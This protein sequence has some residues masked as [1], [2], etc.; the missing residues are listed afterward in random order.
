MS[1]RV[2]ICS[3]NQGCLLGGQVRVGRP[4]ARVCRRKLRSHLVAACRD[5]G[6]AFV[7]GDVSKV[8]AQAAGAAASLTC[9]GGAAIQARVVIMAAGAAAGKFLQY[10]TDAPTMAAQTAYGIQVPL[11]HPAPMHP[12]GVF[13]PIDP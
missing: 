11:S 5:A 12:N 10:E 9:S 6:V 7:A 4:Y 2:V 8:D 1:P 3:R 13:D